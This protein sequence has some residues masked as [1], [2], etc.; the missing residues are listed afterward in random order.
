MNA[1]K[2]LMA[3]SLGVAGVVLPLAAAG[4][5]NA[6]EEETP[7]TG[8][9]STQSPLQAVSSVL[10]IGGQ[11]GHDIQDTA[12]GYDRPDGANGNETEL[13]AADPRFVEGPLSGLLDDPF[14]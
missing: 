11:S 3:A 8:F 14:A 7:T 9:G 1:R 12:N 2:R 4:T 5:A 13:P 10:A 6:A